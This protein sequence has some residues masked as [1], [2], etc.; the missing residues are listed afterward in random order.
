VVELLAPYRKIR[1]K[2]VVR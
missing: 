1:S 2:N